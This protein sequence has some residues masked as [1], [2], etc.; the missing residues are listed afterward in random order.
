[1]KT[2]KQIRILQEEKGSSLKQESVDMDSISITQEELGSCFRGISPDQIQTV[3]YTPIIQKGVFIVEYKEIADNIIFTSERLNDDSMKICCRSFQTKGERSLWTYSCDVQLEM[4]SD[5]EI[6]F[7]FLDFTDADAE[8]YRKQKRFE[9]SENHIAEVIEKKMENF[10][11]MLK[12]MSWIN[13]LSEH[14]EIKEISMEKKDSTKISEKTVQTDCTGHSNRKAKRNEHSPHKIRINGIKV[15]SSDKK[16][17]S[18]LKSRKRQRIT[19][20]WC[21]RGHYRHYK[22]GKKVYIDPYIKGKKNSTAVKKAYTISVSSETIS[23][24]Q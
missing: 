2:V 10:L 4:D 9:A 6:S 24:Y 11:I 12:V 7:K 3:N 20:S 8:I 1:M 19:E 16:L 18:K 21:V 17:V 22:N 13:Y 14:P 5:G 23:K 15:V